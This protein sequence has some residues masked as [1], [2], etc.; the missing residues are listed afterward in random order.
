MKILA[1]RM[2][3]LASLDGESEI[4]FTKEPLKS[5]GIFAITG[6]TGSGKSTI[7]DALCLALFAKTP[8]YVQASEQGIVVQDVGTQTI[9]QSDA[10]G[11]LRRGSAEGFAEVDF[12]G[13]DGFAYRANWSIRRARNKPEGSLQNY[14]M[15]LTRIEANTVI[16][17]RKTELLNEIERLLGL[18][19]DQFTRS[20][21]LAQG[22]FTAFMKAHKNEK[23]ELLEKL[24]GTQIYA[25]ISAKI[26][27]KNK[28]QVN[29]IQ[30]LKDKLGD[31][32]LLNEEQ[33]LEL[34]QSKEKA[35]HDVELASKTLL[36]LGKEQAWH[37]RFAELNKAVDEAKLSLQKAEVEK[38][39]SKEREEKLSHIE[40][41][42]HI[43]PIFSN[44]ENIENQLKEKKKSLDSLE[45]VCLE[46]STK[47]TI[48]EKLVF[49]AELEL[50]THKTKR[51]EAQPQL[52]EAKKLDVQIQEKSAQLTK[53]KLV[54]KNELKQLQDERTQLE[55]NQKKAKIIKQNNEK[56]EDW[57]SNQQEKKGIVENS[58]LIESKLIDAQKIL[59]KTAQVHEILSKNKTQIGKLKSIISSATNQVNQQ[60]TA[61]NEADA[62]IQE[63]KNKLVLIPIHELNTSSTKLQNSKEEFIQ[64]E[65]DWKILF[66]KRRDFSQRKAFFN[67]S[68]TEAQENANRFK[69]LSIERIDVS[70][71]VDQAKIM[72]EKVR[73]A[74]AENV[75][76]LREQLSENESC[77]VCGSKEHPY[78]IHAP[79]HNGVLQEMEKD[80]KKKQEKFDQIRF[81][82]RSIQENLS[83][84]ENAKEKLQ[85][86]LDQ[87]ENELKQKENYWKQFSFLAEIELI[88]DEEKS[89]WL[90]NQLETIKKSLSEIQ[91]QLKNYQKLKT[92]LDQ[93]NEL[94]SKISKNVFDLEQSLK[95][96]SRKLETIEEQQI[97]LSIDLE[98]SEL[99]LSEL[100]NQISRWIGNSDWIEIWKEN[101]AQYVKQIQ[102]FVQNWNSKKTELEKGLKE[103]DL[104]L[105][106]I[107]GSAL[108]LERLENQFAEKEV[109][110]S[111]LTEDFKEVQE[112]RN[113]LFDG[114]SVFEVEKQL[115]KMEENLEQKVAFQNQEKVK[116]SNE[117]IK[118]ESQKSETVLRIS[119]LMNDL[120]KNQQDLSSWL[121]TYNQETKTEF[122]VEQIKDWA[123]ISSD[124]IKAERVSL[125]TIQDNLSKAVT[126]LKERETHFEKHSSERIS[127]RD[128][129]TIL[130]LENETKNYQSEWQKLLNDIDHQL[131]TDQTERLKQKGILDQI[132]SQREVSENWGKLNA[133]IGSATGHVFRQIA[134]EFTLDVLLSYANKHL[135]T[136]SKRYVLQRIPDTLSLQVTDID[137]GNEIRTV[138]SLSGGESFLI[139]LAL[140][141][142]LA[143][144]SSSKMQ[145]ESLFIDEGFG[146]LDPNTLN[147][148]MDALESLH[149]QGRKVGVISHVQE[150][151]ERIPVQIKVSKQSGGK[152]LLEIV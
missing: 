17:G 111:A 41:A 72:L 24:T 151:T 46:L 102:L 73:L 43:K 29:E 120:Q 78:V 18:S 109:Q 11:I 94:L 14:E 52:D 96:E 138:Y 130:N 99:S 4:D 105:E 143:S 54:L 85:K 49:E 39:A 76:K 35:Q 113:E 106:N 149:N 15:S 142:A 34:N 67:Q 136:L 88:S 133:M 57:F 152:S 146:S 134:Q 114:K 90:K 87:V 64:A 23:A 27:E 108:Q 8:R 104:L 117:L 122:S 69:E 66:E 131:K 75:E 81:R 140:A 65:A 37:L 6:P 139:S 1:I 127:E 118:T 25:Q 36:E 62:T 84:W 71:E 135:D 3:N 51:F 30:K 148:A 80:F 33:I 112:K 107:K 119:E 132:E 93:K 124:W 115:Q 19:F 121:Q 123:Q 21:L 141:L 22:D 125:K 9:S 56:L 98:K 74:L 63:L 38:I 89:T 61:Q 12:I 5:A 20:V 100:Y 97:Q 47:K 91:S 58:S 150:M 10:R 79:E 60:K 137:M 70:K 83:K 128:L 77:P 7:L 42:Q 68:E 86:E 95:D 147:I 32:E 45:Q 59:E 55:E 103:L 13:I 53:E 129:E 144:L 110:V 82:E 28:E 126:I 40:S 44:L 92:E 101:N 2:K 145:V 26:Y 31:I 16:P 48:L 50:K 116:N